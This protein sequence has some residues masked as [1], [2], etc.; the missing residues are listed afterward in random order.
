MGMRLVEEEVPDALHELG[1]NEQFTYAFSVVPEEIRTGQDIARPGRVEIGDQVATI[2]LQPTPGSVYL[3][4]LRE[5]FYL[6]AGE[7][8]TRDAV[9]A[10]HQDTRGL[11]CSRRRTK[12]LAE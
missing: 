5:A 2:P 7:R 3:T 9:R 4:L 10:P 8:A 6:P 1:T 12:S 11:R